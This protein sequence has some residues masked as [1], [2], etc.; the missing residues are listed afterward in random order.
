MRYLNVFLIW[1]WANMILIVAAAILIN[2]HY[3]I[4]EGT[5]GN[6]IGLYQ[7]IGITIF[8]GFL[9]T[10]PSLI[11]MLIFHLLY[12]K[13]K[14]EVKEYLKPYCVLILS[15]NMLYLIPYQMVFGLERTWGGPITMPMIFFLTN[16]AGLVGL[17]IEHKKI[18]KE[19]VY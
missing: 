15:I 14:S 13:N 7:S 8:A 12:S 5:I 16:A 2:L 1:L 10:I 6:H 19:T 3:Y 17:Y 9:L 18:T 4:K 11:L